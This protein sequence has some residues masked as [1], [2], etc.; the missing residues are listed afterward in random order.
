MSGRAGG[1][2]LAPGAVPSSTA[3]DPARSMAT[4]EASPLGWAPRE[5]ALGAYVH[6]PFCVA[7]CAYCSFNTAPYLT[8]AVPRYLRAVGGEIDLA[9]GAAWAGPVR[10]ATV[11]FGGGTPSVLTAAELASVLERL[12]ARFGLAA[13]AEITVECNPES[14]S[15][16]RLA[17]YR[18]AG[19]NRISLGVQSLD[20]RILAALDRVHSAAEARAAFDIA[21]HA[22]FD[23]VSA[24]LIYGLPGLDLATWEKTVGELLGWEPDHLSAYALT[25]DG[26][27]RWRSTGVDGLPSEEVVIGQ[28][29]LL[30]DLGRSA[31]FEHYEISNYARPR[32]R[33]AHNQVYWRAEEYLAFGPGACGFLGRVRYA[34][35][36]P[37]ERYCA[38]VEEGTLPI[39]TYETLTLRQMLAERLILGLRL[40]DGVPEGWLRERIALEPGRLP[41][42]L[43]A[44][45]ERGLLVLGDGRAHLTEDGFLLSDTLFAELL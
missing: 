3:D 2:V 44:W 32:R 12:R 11:F 8:E 22:G 29:R 41:A 39:G 23:N 19:V 33:S 18:A 10:L 31:G 38:L 24:D 14:V 20:D 7:R 36:K 26:G 45:Q 6:V 1:G 17:G 40:A 25:L 4:S 34:N 9:G 28:Y 13:D 42:L 27:S 35:V 30:A 43:D 37:T 21:R 16:D 15:R 5:A